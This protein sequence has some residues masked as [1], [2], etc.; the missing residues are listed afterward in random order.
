MGLSLVP[1]GALWLYFDVLLLTYVSV[2]ACVCV[3]KR[4]REIKRQRQDR[5][6][7]MCVN[8]GTC[9]PPGMWGVTGRFLELVLS[10][11]SVETKWGLTGYVD[12]LKKTKVRPLGHLISP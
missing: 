10:F 1:T 7:E 3:C 12:A 6:R 9:T 4:D 8:S 5:D 2:C 11:N